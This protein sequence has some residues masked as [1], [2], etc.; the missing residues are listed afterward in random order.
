M[1]R[2]P[3]NKC[4]YPEEDLPIQTFTGQKTK[5]QAVGHGD[6]RLLQHC[7]LTGGKNS[8]SCDGCLDFLLWNFNNFMC[9][10]F[11]ISCEMSNDIVWNLGLEI[12]HLSKGKTAYTLL[13][14]LP[15]L[16]VVRLTTSSAA[17]KQNGTHY[18][19]FVHRLLQPEFELCYLH[20]EVQ[21]LTMFKVA[22]FSSCSRKRIIRNVGSH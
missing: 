13:A 8:R 10:Y 9:I 6:Y 12:F 20:K 14:S 1:L 2:N 16:T 4:L 17:R 22:S 5:E 19:M 7:Q 21:N 18:V 11:T 3:H 15:F